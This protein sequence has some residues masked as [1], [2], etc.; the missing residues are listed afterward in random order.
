MNQ[1][2]NKIYYLQLIIAFF[3]LTHLDYSAGTAREYSDN[4]IP[5]YDANFSKK[6]PT[7]A[8]KTYMDR[9]RG[10]TVLPANRQIDGN[11]LLA[12]AKI[13]LKSAYESRLTDTH[14]FDLEPID[15]RRDNQW[16]FSN[17]IY[18]WNKKI[19]VPEAPLTI[20][21]ISKSSLDLLSS[22]NIEG[23]KLDYAAIIGESLCIPRID[24]DINNFRYSSAP[25]NLAPH[26]H[27]LT[28]D[29]EIDAIE[30]RG[31]SYHIKRLLNF[32]PDNSWHT[33]QDK[34][35][36]IFQRRLHVPANNIEKLDIDF[37]PDL[38]I[39]HINVRLIKENSLS[40]I[41]LKFNKPQLVALLNGK[42][43]VTLNLKE[44]PEIEN[45]NPWGEN[46]NGLNKQNFY[47]GEISIF[48]DGDN[49]TLQKSK[50]I[51][52][53]I[54]YEK[55]NE[56]QPSLLVPSIVQYN[57]L[58]NRM[59]LNL[60][61]FNKTNNITI[62]NLELSLIP[63]PG[64]SSCSIHIK[65]LTSVRAYS[66][67]TPIYVDRIE[68]GS[69]RW[70]GPMINL[71]QPPDVV[72][73]PNVIAYL[74]LSTFALNNTQS[75]Y[76][77]YDTSL[78]YR[79]NELNNAS[80]FSWPIQQQDIDKITKKNNLSNPKIVYSHGSE[81][82]LDGTISNLSNDNNHLD[83][84][85]TSQNIEFLWPVNKHLHNESWFFFGLKEGSDY[86]ENIYLTLFLLDG[87]IEQ[88]QVTPNLPLK[89]LSNKKIISKISLNI[90]PKAGPYH[91]KLHEMVVFSPSKINYEQ[92]FKTSMPTNIEINSTPIA[93][94][95]QT[96]NLTL[97][98]GRITGNLSNEP[99]K[100]IT[101]LY[102][103][104]NWA[105]GIRLNHLF[106]QELL[107][108]N[109]CP[110][111]IQ[112]NWTNL[113]TK[114][115][116]CFESD[117]GS[118]YIPISAHFG[119]NNSRAKLGTLKSIEW[120]LDALKKSDVET[121]GSFNLSFS[122]LGWEMISAAE[123]LTKYPLLDIQG[124]LVFANQKKFQLDYAS[125]NMTVPLID[126]TSMALIANRKPIIPIENKLFYV[127]QINIHSESLKMSEKWI[128]QEPDLATKNRT[129]SP[130]FW[131]FLLLT[132][133]VFVAKKRFHV[134]LSRIN[135]KLLQKPLLSLRHI[136]V[137]TMLLYFCGLMSTEGTTENYF[138][139]FGGLAIAYLVN[140]IL[141]KI[142]SRNFAIR[143]NTIDHPHNTYIFAFIICL[144]T[145][146]LLAIAMFKL[147]L[148]F[149]TDQ[150]TN[151]MLW[152]IFLEV[153][154]QIFRA[155]LSQKND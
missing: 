15:G 25:S 71:L 21:P 140:S 98:P 31:G 19:G 82:K 110:L 130:I 24:L 131:T 144:S 41:I 118:T 26:G 115:K 43:R 30:K 119:S 58:D 33:T 116:I 113:I 93:L 67:L 107:K 102:P 44:A 63:P 38:T 76:A 141:K 89:I 48:I 62:K 128:F 27:F 39:N 112:L 103:S 54:F 36:V 122:V 70:K 17:S 13:T 80:P 14:K 154:T 90:Q 91:L 2:K 64:K 18:Y 106:S 126:G 145:I 137:A 56:S 136:F 148:I 77:E 139:T 66:L 1:K 10:L 35:S 127:D 135:S 99:V 53:L 149:I 96:N 75:N 111:L 46:F 6:D 49:E 55:N 29:A 117:A 28:I 114:K 4:A 151:I 22:K 69:R 37:L 12:N 92:A 74:P 73:N 40:T 20:R 150:L 59:L 78:T 79:I 65:E 32:S 147:E 125:L 42:M 34:K 138:F 94:N 51:K 68:D 60:H 3:L 23:L 132:P 134:I 11:N 121:S 120:T 57:N 84:K 45:S 61:R 105:L 100:F 104:L 153:A 88:H 109:P 86:I 146:S 8:N 50:P 5:A 83:I 9:M 47:I 52:N 7:L 129:L 123:Q 87:R 155:S 81:L 143:L 97:S 101:S 72:N 95:Y 85:G 124:H 142:S 108:T 16:K 133:L 152:M